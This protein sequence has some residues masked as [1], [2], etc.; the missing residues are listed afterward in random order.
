VLRDDMDA[1]QRAPAGK[2]LVR[3]DEM[4][5]WL[6]SFDRTVPSEGAGA[7]EA[8]IFGFI[9]VEVYAGSHR[10]RLIRRI[11]LVGVR[12]RRHSARRN[13]TNRPRS[14]RRRPVT[15]LLLR[16]SHTTAPR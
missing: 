8:L 1:K 5:E 3:Q 13:P 12:S 6:G 4:S 14:S 2:V 11:E 9:T 15:T 10:T 16:R 7:I